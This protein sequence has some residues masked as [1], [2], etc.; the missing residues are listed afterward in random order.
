[1]LLIPSV[2][3][4]TEFFVVTDRSEY[5][6]GDTII[7]SGTV[8]EI[9][10]GNTLITIQIIHEA[11][12]VHLAQIEVAQDGTFSESVIAEGVLWNEDGEY[13][14]RAS[15]DGQSVETTFLLYIS[16]I[17]EYSAIYE[18]D[19]GNGSFI[20]VEFTISGGTIE[21]ME[22][23]F[24]STALDIQIDSTD[25]GFITLGL[26]RE[27]IDSKKQDE[28][29]DTFIILIDSIEVAYQEIASIDETRVITIN[30]GV[31]DEQIEIIGTLVFSEINDMTVQT[32][33]LEY[34]LNDIVFISGEVGELLGDYAISFKVI[35]P[36]GNTAIISQLTVNEDKTFDYNFEINGALMKDYGT[37]SVTVQYS[38]NSAETTFELIPFVEPL[39]LQIDQLEYHYEDRVSIN[40]TL[41]EF[42]EEELIISVLNQYN[43]TIYTDEIVINEDL[44]FDTHIDIEGQMFGEM[45][46]YT[47]EAVCGDDFTSITFETLSTGVT[48][49]TSAETYYE[50]AIVIV[51]GEISDMDWDAED[52]SLLLEMYDENKIELVS[53]KYTGF[54]S[55]Y[56]AFYFTIHTLDKEQ[57]DYTGGVDVYVTVQNQT[58]TTHFEYINEP[59]NTVE[60]LRAD[61][62]N[63]YRLLATITDDENIDQQVIIDIKD[64]IEEI[65][66]DIE[67]IRL[68]DGEH[69]PNCEVRPDL[70]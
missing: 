17:P 21:N 6:V 48:V 7:V 63:I 29:D 50:D 18:V 62:T 65:Q 22:L 58:G 43:S 38:D 68:S 39:T 4:G 12:Y 47:I 44:T 42:T 20:D 33:K 13:T 37:Y 3:Y 25:N 27:L 24:E 54:I 14:V 46:T 5:V 35:A 64:I 16:E 57:W 56:N 61:I 23:D 34:Y 53:T 31:G 67:E 30:F 36:N 1:M 9:I 26:P 69:E 8:N 32:D 59:N 51:S 11:T 70:C 2:V 60:A 15:Y 66:Y 55:E 45:G 52:I 40:G 19:I 28:S 10:G 49:I 41:A